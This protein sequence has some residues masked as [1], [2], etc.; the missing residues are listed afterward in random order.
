METNDLQMIAIAPL[1]DLLGGVSDMTITRWM[2]KR[3]FPQPIVAGGNGRR[4][5]RL[6]DVADWLEANRR[7][8]RNKPGPFPKN[9]TEAKARKPQAS[10]S[11][12]KRKRHRSLTHQFK[13]A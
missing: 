6:K 11:L 13:G 3:K 5:W 12:L 9:L 10:E 8:P 7:P 4:F 1:R 2:D